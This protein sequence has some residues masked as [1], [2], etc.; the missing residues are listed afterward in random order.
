VAS[1]TANNCVASSLDKDADAGTTWLRIDFGR[2]VAFSKIAVQNAAADAKSELTT[3]VQA[4]IV[5]GDIR[6]TDDHAHDAV[7]DGRWLFGP[8]SP[9]FAP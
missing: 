9:P 4:Q 6:I 5:G 1:S 7:D 8:L 3:T 2:A